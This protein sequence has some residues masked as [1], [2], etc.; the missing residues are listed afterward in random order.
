MTTETTERIDLAGPRPDVVVE[1]RGGIVYLSCRKGSGVT[2]RVI[3][4]DTDPDARGPDRD[5]YEPRTR[6]PPTGPGTRK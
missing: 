5:I 1:L 2:V 4:Y 3:D 6:W